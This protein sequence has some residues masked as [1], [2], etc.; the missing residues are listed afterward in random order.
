MFWYV[1]LMFQ[2]P[3]SHGA[4]MP[5]T[6]LSKLNLLVTF[7]PP[8]PPSSNRRNL[9]P[10]ARKELKIP[11][12]LWMNLNSPEICLLDFWKLFRLLD[13]RE[14]TGISRCW[15]DADESF[16]WL[17][18][19]S[20]FLLGFSRVNNASIW[21][22][23]IYRYPYSAIMPA[24][25]TFP[26]SCT[27]RGDLTKSLFCSKVS[28][29]IIMPV[30]RVPAKTRLREAWKYPR[31]PFPIQLAVQLNDLNLARAASRKMNGDQGKWQE[32]GQVALKAWNLPDCRGSPPQSRWLGIPIFMYAAAGDT[33]GL[34]QIARSC[35]KSGHVN[36]A[37]AAFVKAGAYVPAFELLLSE[38]GALKRPCSLVRTASVPKMSP[39]RWNVAP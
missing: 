3:Q 18:D 1:Q 37:F 6:W 2:L 24:L 31:C 17:F 34:I 21:P 5:A 29:P 16:N 39:S 12:N 26:I 28:L 22:I 23:K 27:C 7:Y 35:Q 9:S 14:S 4:L 36:L 11:L 13:W 38:E 32:L 30:W 8:K 20:H 19:R 15:G 10:A 33:D 25:I